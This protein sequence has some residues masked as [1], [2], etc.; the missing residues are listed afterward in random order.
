MATHPVTINTATKPLSYTTP[1]LTDATILHVK[2]DETV[3]WVVASP[4]TQY[5]VAILFFPNTPFKDSLGNPVY[6]FEGPDSDAANGKIGGKI[7]GSDATYPYCV[8]VFDDKNVRTYT[9]DP[10][11]IVGNGDDARAEIAS[12]LADLKDADAKL[13]SR[14]RVRKQIE[15]IEHKLEHLVNELK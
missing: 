1:K 12:A 4:T 9:D 3:A 13:S 15:A 7:T 2:A 14:P 6:A 5:R 8:A 10:K 11:I